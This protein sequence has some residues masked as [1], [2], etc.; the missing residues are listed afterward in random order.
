M[1]VE[2]YEKSLMSG[3]KKLLV[4]LKLEDREVDE[5]ENVINRLRGRRW[6]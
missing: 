3:L 6:F 1:L 5:V 2:E 4:E